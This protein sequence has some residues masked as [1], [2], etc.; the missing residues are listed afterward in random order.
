MHAGS[1]FQKTAAPF[2]PDH[3]VLFGA[4]L[5]ASNIFY[6]H[7]DTVVWMQPELPE[8]LGDQLA[9]AGLARTYEDSGWC[10]VELTSSAIVKRKGRQLDL[11]KRGR[12]ERY[13]PD[14]ISG[15]F[16][17]GEF[18]LM[19]CEQNRVPPTHPEDMT[20]E[21]ETVKV[22]TG[23]GD[24][25]VVAKMYRTLFELVAPTIKEADYSRLGWGAPEGVK[26]AKSLPSMSS[27]T[28]VDVGGNSIGKGAALDLIRIFTEKKNM[29]S[30]G[31][32]GCSRG[33]EGAQAAAEMIRLCGSLT[34]V[35]AFLP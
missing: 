21:L 22:F 1:L 29:V 17:E 28:S 31:L 24:L 35:R 18:I 30:V 20:L 33:L 5:R 23:K 3:Q 26:V 4:G 32:A 25:P 16:G 34:S 2:T 7:Q 8:G 10:Y 6:S 27:L 9:E 12:A 14:E 11:S 19:T 13:Q 15:L